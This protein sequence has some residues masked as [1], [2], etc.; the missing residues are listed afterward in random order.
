M[1]EMVKIG[2]RYEFYGFGEDFP[3][4]CVVIYIN[5]DVAIMEA[6]FMYAECEDQTMEYEDVV[7]V[8]PDFTDP[9]HNKYS[10]YL[11]LDVETG[12]IFP[13][14]DRYYNAKACEE[15]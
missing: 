4:E 3:I 7:D 13:D 12:D 10:H 9:D 6:V 8:Y 5:G 14:F 2:D 1:E 11:V 15:Q